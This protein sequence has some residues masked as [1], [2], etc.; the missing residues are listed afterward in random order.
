M[1]PKK[2]SKYGNIKTVYRG[3]FFRSRSEAHYAM[4]L[5]S[6]KREGIINYAMFLDSE[7]RKGII[8]RWEYEVPVK[9]HTSSGKK[10]GNYVV[11]FFVQLQDGREEWVEIKGGKRMETALWRWKWKHAKLEYP[12]RIWKVIRAKDLL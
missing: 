3:I 12:E 7:K 9:L 4:F 5:D 2:R 1:W 10:I 8:T 11:D 6:E